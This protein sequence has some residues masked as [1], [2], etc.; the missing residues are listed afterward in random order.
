MKVIGNHQVN[1][2]AMAQSAHYQETPSRPIVVKGG[3]VFDRAPSL[4]VRPLPPRH[5]G[6]NPFFAW[7]IGT[8]SPRELAASL[9]I[10]SKIAFQTRNLLF[11][12]SGGE[13]MRRFLGPLLIISITIATSIMWT[14]TRAVAQQQEQCTIP[15]T[16]AALQPANI[17]VMVDGNSVGTVTLSQ[18]GSTSLSF[19]CSDGSHAF[20][21]TADT[22]PAS[23]NGSFTVDSSH[24]SFSMVMRPTSTGLNCSLNPTSP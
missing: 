11:P 22:P 1:H 24:T 16:S 6:A 20:T 18:T 3:Y 14:Q 23:C 21:F 17:T 8:S 15:A 13:Q 7:A 9:V 5:R 2:K 19:A 12:L 4:G 10:T